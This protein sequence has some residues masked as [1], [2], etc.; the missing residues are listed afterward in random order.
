MNR[1]GKPTNKKARGRF[2]EC[3][4]RAVIIVMHRIPRYLSVK[5]PTLEQEDWLLLDGISDERVIA[6]FYLPNP[7][8]NWNMAAIELLKRLVLVAGHDATELDR[9]FRASALFTEEWDSIRRNGVTWGTYLTLQAIR[10]N[11]SERGLVP[12]EVVEGI[13]REGQIALITGY[14]NV[15]KSPLVRDLAFHVQ[16]GL[17]WLGRPTT[18]RQVVVV[19]FEGTPGE[20]RTNLAGLHKR[21]GE[22]FSPRGY[23]YQARD[24]CGEVQ[25]LTLSNFEWRNCFA[26]IRSVLEDSSDT[27]V[28]VD[29]AQL[30]FRFKRNYALQIMALFTAIREMLRDFPGSTVV[31][32]VNQDRENRRRAKSNLYDDPIRWLEGIAGDLDILNRCDVRLG[33]DFF[34]DPAFR[35]FN[36]VRRGEG[37]V[38]PIIVRP[39]GAECR[40]GFEAAH[41]DSAALMMR[42]T[43]R[44]RIYWEALPTEFH[45]QEIVA[46]RI[47]P[48]ATLSRI[49]TRARSVGLLESP[50]GVWRKI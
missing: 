37:R 49:L 31:L 14:Y 5:P 26:F 41:L 33:F 20:Y 40:A 48:K 38:S 46:R 18:K 42:L 10:E 36:G 3:G 13:I 45:F 34:D 6:L 11:C 17:P 24:V 23:L 29:P 2:C 28:I 12:P 47:V 1:G 30:L 43:P 7:D 27:L 15:G 4:P 32:V 22:T 21:Y 19:D 16:N 9:F 50:G 44:Q 39:V 8:C 35:V 25:P